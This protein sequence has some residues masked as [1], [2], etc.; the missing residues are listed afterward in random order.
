MEID[1]PLAFFL[2]TWR[3]TRSIEDH[4]SRT[5]GFLHGTATFT[6][7]PAPEPQAAVR[8][9]EAGEL[10]FG[11]YRGPAR[12]SL[13]YARRANGTLLVSFPD[14]RPFIELDLRGGAWRSEHL[15]DQD[16]HEIVTRLL[17]ADVVEEGWRVRGPASDYDALTTLVRVR[18]SSRDGD[19]GPDGLARP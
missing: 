2:G 5:R 18:E 9:D 12:R 4:R 17:S 8:Y 10:V 3:L 13:D 14:G 15:C 1:D 16:R 19:R 11:T 6:R 7:S